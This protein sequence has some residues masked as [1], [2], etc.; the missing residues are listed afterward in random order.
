MIAY[1]AER[2]VRKSPNILKAIGKIVPKPIQSRFVLH[3]LNYL[4]KEFIENGELDFLTNKTAKF[5]ITDADLS[6]Q[7][8]FNQHAL[9]ERPKDS[10]PDVVFSANTHALILMAS[11]KV[12]P[13]T[14]FFNRDLSIGGDTELGL[15]IKNLIDLFDID[16]LPPPLKFA[17]DKWSEKLLASK[18]RDIA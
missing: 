7:F 18:N 16:Q 8:G 6:W 9:I 11:K 14:L 2:T 13:D 4:A 3:Q 10:P 1:L 12:D 17:L 15:E 5:E